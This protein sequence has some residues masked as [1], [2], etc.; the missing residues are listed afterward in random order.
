M[1]AWGGILALTGF[2]YSAVDRALTLAPAKKPAKSFWS[3]GYAWGTFAQKP[4]KASTRVTIE[5]LGGSLALERVVLT[6][7]GEARAERA[8]TARP[9]KEVALTVKAG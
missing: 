6:G 9:G 7:Y 1:A 2:R 3:T 4:G 5:V 8:I